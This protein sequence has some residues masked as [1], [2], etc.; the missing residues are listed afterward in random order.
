M[1]LSVVRYSDGRRAARPLEP[2]PSRSRRFVIVEDRRGRVG[3][4]DAAAG[5]LVVYASE[6]RAFALARL[7]N[8]LDPSAEQL[9][10][11]LGEGRRGAPLLRAITLEY[12]G[13]VCHRC[14]QPFKAGQRA[15]WNPYTGLTR[16]VRAC[17]L[18]IAAAGRKRRRG[19]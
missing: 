12:D 6:R 19:A 5:E 13:S 11:L 2:A 1:S 4:L 3:V 10:A 18:E 9:A 16:H 15:R 7:L 14:G 8:A 17:P